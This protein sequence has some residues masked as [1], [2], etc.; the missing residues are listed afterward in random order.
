[1]KILGIIFIYVFADKIYKL[2]EKIQKEF[3]EAS[4]IEEIIIATVI[5]ICCIVKLVVLIAFPIMIFF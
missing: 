1:M 5:L 2:M 3:T 4:L